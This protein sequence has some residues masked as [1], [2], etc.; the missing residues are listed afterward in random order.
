M[1]AEVAIL[2][3]APQPRPFS[4][5]WSAAS[6]NICEFTVVVGHPAHYELPLA[7][8]V[9]ERARKQGQVERHRGKRHRQRTAVSHPWGGEGLMGHLIPLCSRR[10][11]L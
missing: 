9:G 1:L 7:V 4:G 11:R 6:L 3:S 8:P 5:V 10:T 2:S